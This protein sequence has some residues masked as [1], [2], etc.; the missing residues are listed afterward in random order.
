MCGTKRHA[1]GVRSVAT[2]VD[3]IAIAR[4]T[5]GPLSTFHTPQDDIPLG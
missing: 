1:S 2:L 5:C 4:L 3:S